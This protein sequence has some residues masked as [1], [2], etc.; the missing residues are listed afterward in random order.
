ML[1]DVSYECAIEYTV[2]LYN[3]FGVTVILYF[4]YSIGSQVL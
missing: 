3:F 4:V 1:L 2:I